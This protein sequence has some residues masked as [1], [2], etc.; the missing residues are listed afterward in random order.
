MRPGGRWRRRTCRAAP[1]SLRLFPGRRGHPQGSVFA[2]C[3]V[4]CWWAGAVKGV[5]RATGHSR[6]HLPQRAQPRPRHALSSGV[7]TPTA[8]V[9]TRAGTAM[10]GRLTPTSISTAGRDFERVI[11][12]KVN[13][14]ER[15]RAQIQLATVEARNGGR[16][17]GY[18]SVPA[19]GGPPAAHAGLPARV[20][21]GALAPS[22]SSPS[23]P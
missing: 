16:G 8:A 9:A 15:L 6:N 2:I 17:R 20:P 21:G 23:P 3:S 11:F 5:C 12:A 7:S 18:R 13:V 14:A 1:R 19:G 22:A 10:R 4:Y